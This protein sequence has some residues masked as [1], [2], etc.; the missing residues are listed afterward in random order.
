MEDIDLFE[1]IKSFGAGMVANLT[2]AREADHE[3]A[4]VLCEKMRDEVLNS[5]VKLLRHS[6]CL[7]TLLQ[8]LF[9]AD[10]TKVNDSGAIG[11]SFDEEDDGRD[12][13]DDC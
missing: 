11:P 7:R 4:K 9:D 12:E 10:F 2:C 1:F 5:V 3:S 6:D 8:T 13:Q